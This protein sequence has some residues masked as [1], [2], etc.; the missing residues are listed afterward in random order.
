MKTSTKIFSSFHSSGNIKWR[1]KVHFFFAHGIE[2]IVVMKNIVAN[3]GHI[4]EVANRMI[5]ETERQQEL[6]AEAN[7][8]IMRLGDY[9]KGSAR[10]EGFDVL[11]SQQRPILNNTTL[12]IRNFFQLIIQTADDYESFDRHTRS[13][14]SDIK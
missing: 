2:R 8:A 9:W 11:Y 14:F 1:K 13:R 7:S 12:D 10:E 6:L 4:R 3:T 5:I